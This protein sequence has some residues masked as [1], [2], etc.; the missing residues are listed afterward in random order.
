VDPDGHV[1]PKLLDF[2]IAKLKEG[3][4]PVQTEDGRVLGTPRYLAPE[5]IRSASD[6]DGRAD[7]FSTAVVLYETLT[8]VSPFV[9][10][11]PAQELVAVIERDIA[12]HE[13]IDPRLWVEI[14]RAVSK[15]PDER[16][17]TAHDFAAALRASIDETEESL[18][19]FLKQTAQLPGWEPPPQILPSEP[20]Q[21]GADE[22]SAVVLAPKR[23]RSSAIWLVATALVI[24][25]VVVAVFVAARLRTRMSTHGGSAAAAVPVP[26]LA[27]SSPTPGPSASTTATAKPTPTQNATQPVR[28]AA[29]PRP[30]ATTPGF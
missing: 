19:E 7:I 24:V 4:A 15:S 11:N 5:R 9:G 29:H 6:V 23:K 14:Q 30:V 27:A 13:R 18:Q 22:Q 17:A 8:G 26:T 1:T 10:T 2:G 20:P 16:H 3:E 21:A 12:P 28:P 25:G